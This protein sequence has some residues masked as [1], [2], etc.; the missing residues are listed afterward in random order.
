MPAVVSAAARGGPDGVLTY[1]IENS[2]PGSS[3]GEAWAQTRAAAARY[4]LAKGD[5]QGGLHANEYIF[6]LQHAGAF[7]NLRLAHSAFVN[8]DMPGAARM[9]AKSHAFVDDGAMAGLQV[10]NGKIYLQR[11][12]EQTHQPIGKPTEVTGYGIRTMMQQTQDP[13]AFSTMVNNERTTNE[14]IQHNRAT[15]VETAKQRAE[16]GRHNVVTEE[17]AARGHTI[18][19]SNAAA[20]NQ[21]GYD[22]INAQNQRAE[23]NRILREQLARNAQEKAD[24]QVATGLITGA[25]KEAA[26]IYGG[27]AATDPLDIAGNPMTPAMRDKASDIYASLVGKKDGLQSGTAQTIA[28]H[29]LLPDGDPRK[30][31]K[32]F[33]D[34]ETSQVV[35]TDMS[36]KPI[37]YLP[38]SSVKGWMPNA[39]MTPAE[40]AA[41][42]RARK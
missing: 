3:V 14:H 19:A 24:A 12:D 16:T 21:L 11:F 5:A 27:D 8:G 25:R 20:A 6:Q 9:L 31:Y 7:E 33:V 36:N 41:A 38:I 17:E 2:R 18:T 35:V 28:R 26:G 34:K 10:I 15:E 22:R 13:K 40:A 1:I 39:G 23:E 4:F 37:S 30:G 29:L 42:A 32:T